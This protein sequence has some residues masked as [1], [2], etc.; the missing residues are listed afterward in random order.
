M[1]E[2][3]KV[4]VYSTP[5]CPWCHRAEEFLREKGVEFESIDVSVDREAAQRMVEKSGQMGVPV[6]E[7]DGKMVVGFDRPRIAELLGIKE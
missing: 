5:S 7:I 6:I 1:A 3:P 2:K 4:R